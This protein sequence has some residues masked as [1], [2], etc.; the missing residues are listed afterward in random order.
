VTVITNSSLL[1]LDKV[2]EDLLEADIVL[3]SLDAVSPLTFKH[4]NRP[5]SSLNIN[6][7]IKGLI[8][9][10]K[11]F[12]GQLWL[13]ILFCRVIN[14]DHTE[15]ER[16]CEKIEDIKPDRIQVGTVVRPSTEDFAYPL[17][18]NQLISINEI[19]GPKVELISNILPPNKETYFTNKEEKIV[20]LIDRRPCTCD[21]ICSALGLHSNEALKYLDKLMKEDRVRYKLHHHHGYYQAVNI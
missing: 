9:F 14:D 17:S 19:L 5:E 21:D 7:I 18:E 13:E 20:N 8:D 10:K 16:M 12:R 6:D 11:E 2:K 1:F 4:I 3:P 15:V